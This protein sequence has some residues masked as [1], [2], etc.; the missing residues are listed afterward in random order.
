M[1]NVY[2]TTTTTT[3]VGVRNDTVEMCYYKSRFKCIII[4]L[5]RRIANG[6]SFR[7]AYVLLRCTFAIRL[8]RVHEWNT[9][10]TDADYKRG[11]WEILIA[12]V[13]TVV[14]RRVCF[15]I[16]TENEFWF[17]DFSFTSFYARGGKPYVRCTRGVRKAFYERDKDV[18]KPTTYARRVR[19]TKRWILFLQISP[20]L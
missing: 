2:G 4:L 7:K 13:C 15:L 17:F 6:L 12:V 9:H 16:F 1:I 8:R 19:K 5:P 18:V 20:I 11:C 10:S 14:E 3:T